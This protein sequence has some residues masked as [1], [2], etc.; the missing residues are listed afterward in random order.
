M[1]KK[2]ITSPAGENMTATGDGSLAFAVRETA[3]VVLGA[4]RR[5]TGDQSL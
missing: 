2:I 5:I 3:A 1:E 4:L